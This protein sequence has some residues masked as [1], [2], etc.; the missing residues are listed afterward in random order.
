MHGVRRAWATRSAVNLPTRMA[1]TAA[2][3]R[4]QRRVPPTANPRTRSP[5]RPR[6]GPPRPSPRPASIRGSRPRARPSRGSRAPSATRRRDGPAH[7]GP[8][9]RAWET[10][11]ARRSC[12]AVAAARAETTRTAQPVNARPA[13]S[14]NRA[15][16]GRCG[17]RS[18]WR[19]WTRARRPRETLAPQGQR[20]R[21]ESAATRAAPGARP[22]RE[23]ERARRAAP[24]PAALVPVRIRC[25]PRGGKGWW[26]GQ[27]YHGA[28][29]AGMCWTPMR[30]RKTQ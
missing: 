29:T 5:R 18:L 20:W 30:L 12:C 3:H 21:T 16:T 1:K 8:S 9:R 24:C 2:G 10:T 19:R 28:C 22:A 11:R 17:P 26:A 15:A 25:G 14:A 6:G 7:S 4:H 27:R 13:T 23:P